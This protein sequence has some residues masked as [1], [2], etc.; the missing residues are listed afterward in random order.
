MSKT[1]YIIICNLGGPSREY[2]LQRFLFNLFNDKHIIPVNPVLRFILAKII[3][4]FRWRR[5]QKE[6]DKMGGYS[7]ILENTQFQ[8]DA[9]NNALGT[10]YKVLVTMRYSKPFISSVLKSIDRNSVE[11]IIF[12]P[13]YPQFSVTSSKT[14][15]EQFCVSASNLNLHNV[16]VI[17]YFYKNELYIQSC[18]NKILEEINTLQNKNGKTVILFS[19]HGIPADF[20]TK[21]QDPYKNHIEETTNLI[22]T[23]L[24]KHSKIEFDYE[25]CYQSRVG[26]KKW[27]EPYIHNTI[28]K[29]SGYNMIIFPVAFV[30]EHLETLAELDCKYHELARSCGIAEYRRAKTLGTCPIFIECLKSICMQA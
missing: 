5:S 11:K 30:S 19:A 9:L 25:V 13:L 12:L 17:P 6:Y 22:V 7:P 27:L 1:I 3:V 18:T 20:I 23:S 15:I 28:P 4:F 14:A 26:P 10:G 2:S 8:A 29:Y 16:A 24:R 21:F